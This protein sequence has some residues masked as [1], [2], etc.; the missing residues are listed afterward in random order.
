MKPPE[1]APP[2]PTQTVETADDGRVTIVRN[3]YNAPDELVPFPFGLEAEA[4]RRLMRSGDLPHAKLG[5]KWYAKRSDVL[6]L[7]DL[8]KAPPKP[9]PSTD[10]TT[11][12]ANLAADARRVRRKAS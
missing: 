4:A 2:E 9:A 11:H 8:F 3:V 6:A 5:R 7:V 10:V 1:K 12:L